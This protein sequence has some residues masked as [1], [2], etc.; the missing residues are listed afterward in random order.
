MAY[1][2]GACAIPRPSVCDTTTWCVRYHDRPWVKPRP[3]A[4]YPQPGL[5]LGLPQAFRVLQNRGAAQYVVVSPTVGRQHPG[6][7]ASAESDQVGLAVVGDVIPGQPVAPGN[8]AYHA[9]EFP[10]WAVTAGFIV[11]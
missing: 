10:E 1:R 8:L 2:R 9:P 7:L 5:V 6:G 3:Q 4:R 11:E